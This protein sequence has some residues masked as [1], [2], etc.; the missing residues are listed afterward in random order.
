M[1]NGFALLVE[2][3]LQLGFGI[4]PGLIALLLPLGFHL[5]GLRLHGAGRSAY[6]L[7]HLLLRLGCGADGLVRLLL[8]T[9]C[10]LLGGVADGL[11]GD[12]MQFGDWL[13]PDAPPEDPAAAKADADVVARVSGLKVTYALAS[14]E[15]EVLHGV[16]GASQVLAAR[17][18]NLREG[19]KALVVAG[20]SSAVAASSSPSRA[21]K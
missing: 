1:V 20:K 12:A 6:H 2:Q 16:E 5:V 7:A 21:P 19:A 11:L 8:R 9:G 3:L 18:D 4:R 13:D 14:R 10:R 17:F 15:T